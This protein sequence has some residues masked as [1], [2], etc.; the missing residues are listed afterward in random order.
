MA[1]VTEHWVF[2]TLIMSWLIL[3]L[4]LSTA[5]AQSMPPSGRISDFRD[6][7]VDAEEGWTVLFNG[8][9]FTGWVPV[10][11]TQDG[12]A[13]KFLEHEVSD[14]TTFSV[15]DG[16]LLT[17]GKPSGYLRTETVYENYVFHVEVRLMAPGNSGV[18]A[19]IQKDWRCF[20]AWA[21]LSCLLLCCSA[22]GESEFV[23]LL[24]GK[25][26]DD[27]IHVGEGRNGYSLQDGVLV[28]P[29]E[30]TG[31]LFSRKEY[32][33]FVLRFEF[34]LQEASNNGVAIRSPLRKDA[35]L[36]GIEIQILDDQAPRYQA[37]VKP[38]QYHGSIY[39]V[40][41]AKRGF[42]K[43]VGDWNEQEIRADDR[44]IRVTLNGAVIIDVDLSNITDPD[45]LREHPGLLRRN[46]HI[47]FLGHRSRVDFRNVRIK[48]LP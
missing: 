27:W 39:G 5:I 32:S 41:G 47:G 30:E 10:L 20:A 25:N 45:I 8:R 29:A 4:I 37:I 6:P 15:K 12:T 36:T 21:V 31:N 35:H 3:G 13:K 40:V 9:D 43:K 1:I 19:H 16:K 46:G 42:L 2:K 18:L 38:V 14:Q 7:N 48:E 23:R 17:T 22:K 34:R 24:N 11:K 33:N 44:R 26:L 28:C